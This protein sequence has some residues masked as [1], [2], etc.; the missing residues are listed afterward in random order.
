M[1]TA[2]PTKEMIYSA[3]LVGFPVDLI[4]AFSTAFFLWFLG[5]PMIE[6][7][8]RIKLKYGLLDFNEN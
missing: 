8:E 6:K 2:N 3:F 1:V 4:H 7:L 5:E